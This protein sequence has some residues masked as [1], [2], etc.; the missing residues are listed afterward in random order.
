MEIRGKA[1]TTC[2]V[3]RGKAFTSCTNK[4]NVM[5]HR[6]AIPQGFHLRVYLFT[7]SPA[8][9]AVRAYAMC[10]AAE[11]YERRTVYFYSLFPGL[12]WPEG[13]LP[14]TLYCPAELQ[15]AL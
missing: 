7:T 10:Y 15:L 8:I 3:I 6:S 9:R 4:T 11:L 13:T 5:H 14:S 12:K 1:F 2:S